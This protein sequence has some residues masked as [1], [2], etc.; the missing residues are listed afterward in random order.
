MKLKT[1]MIDPGHGGTDPGAVHQGLIEKNLNLKV[2]LKVRDLLL[3]KY[4]VTI[5]M[6]RT[7]DETVDLDERTAL[8][9]NRNVDYY[10]SIHHNAGG[11]QG[12]ESF[13]Y[14]GTVSQE[15]I[16]LQSSIHE[17]FINKLGSKY[18]II[19]R[20]Q[21]RAN[22]HVL[23]ETKMSA[24]LLELLFLDNA[25]DRR[26]LRRERFFNDASATI[27][28]GLAKAL[29][30]PSKK[31]N[32][33]EFSRVIAGSFTEKENAESRVTFLIQNK[34]EALI[35]PTVVSG[36]PYFRVQAGAF[37]KREN[38]LQRIAA[39]QRLGIQDAFIVSDP[40]PSPIQS[41][42]FLSIQGK[43]FLSAQQLDAFAASVNRESPTLGAYYLQF[44]NAY[45]IRGDIA[46]AQALHETN[47][48]RFTGIVKPDQNNFAGIG[49]TGP[50]NSGA[51]FGTPSD[52]VL[53]HIQHLYAYASDKPLPEKYPLRD[54][55]F[56]L[57]TRGSSKTWPDLNGKWAVP[58]DN[59]GESI[60]ALYKRVVEF[61]IKDLNQRV[62]ELNKLLASL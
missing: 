38:A 27:A 4:Q 19:N 20:G 16:N 23:R 34:I 36:K 59:Y 51:R 52:G 8:A 29:S 46:F 25:N 14:N 15:T 49:A 10:C 50:G 60:L 6:T 32:S 53:A 58:G 40:S 17:T 45:G 39:L 3:S 7:N 33:A 22:F 28:D 37:T 43:S 26:I 2:A 54:P 5:V 61:T 31:E 13:I 11:G 21:K 47:F 55:R 12:F 30:L 57:V 62:D 35:I 56:R 9:N 1:L 24:L 48:F 44:G 42:T 18:N 41:S